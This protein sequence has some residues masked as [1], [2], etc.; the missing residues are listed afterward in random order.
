[1]LERG[2]HSRGRAAERINDRVAGKRKHLNQPGGQ[3]ERIRRGMFLR[4]CAG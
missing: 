2:N 4:G 1:M 3:F